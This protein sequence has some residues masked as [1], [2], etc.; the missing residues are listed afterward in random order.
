MILRFHWS[1][2]TF[3]PTMKKNLFFYFLISLSLFSC[4]ENG[5]ELSVL[6]DKRI[7]EKTFSGIVLVF[8]GVPKKQFVSLQQSE[9]IGG[10]MYF[11]SAGYY[12][13]D[14]LIRHTI[15]PK[16]ESIDTIK[17][18]LKRETVEVNLERFGLASDSYL[19]FDGDTIHISYDSEANPVVEVK[20]REVKKYDY[21]FETFKRKEIQKKSLT[22]FEKYFRK[23]PSIDLNIPREKR[24]SALKASQRLKAEQLLN[25]LAIENHNLDSLKNLNLISPVIY[26]YYFKKNRYTL[27]SYLAKEKLLR[28][29]TLSGVENQKMQFFKEPISIKNI[30]QDENVKFYSF[31][32]DF[33]FDHYLPGYFY[34]ET[35]KS[36][37]TFEKFGGSHFEWDKIFDNVNQSSMFPNTIKE[38]ILFNTMKNIVEDLPPEIVNDY[39][40][41]F[42][43]T[44]EESSY[45]EIIDEARIEEYST[46]KTILLNN[47]GEEVFLEDILKNNKDKIIYIDFWASWCHPCLKAIPGTL[48]IKNQYSDDVEFLFISVE[49]EEKDWTEASKKMG[50]KENNFILRNKYTSTFIKSLKLD[51]LPRYIIIGKDGEVLNP[52]ALS[53][54]EGVKEL[55]IN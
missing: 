44:I 10:R 50:L 37:Y 39:Y 23:I 46:S 27:Y 33:L 43:S 2:N 41:S 30:I 29:S 21:S 36:T 20:G 9:S 45:K 4:K 40:A 7:S 35:T 38:L 28:P 34:E 5:K 11:G 1:L 25:S 16:P 47:G 22:A 55:T 53:P 13:D 54:E 42:K 18:S 32:H 14:N 12:L 8:D 31:Y 19:F 24:D 3:I 48:K 15:Q 51:Y 26:N 49:K 17:L 6:S 52:N